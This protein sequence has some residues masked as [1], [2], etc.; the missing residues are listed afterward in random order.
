MTGNFLTEVVQLVFSQTAFN[1]SACVD[2]RGNVALEEY[3][4]AFFAFAFSFPEV[5]EADFVHSGG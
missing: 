1:E 2:T 5:V 4:I 3:Q